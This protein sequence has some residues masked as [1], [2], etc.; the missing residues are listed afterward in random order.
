[1]GK[2]IREN[3]I[4]KEKT[5]KKINILTLVIALFL[6]A[7]I[8]YTPTA[9]AMGWDLCNAMLQQI[10]TGVIDT[11]CWNLTGEEYSKP[12][13]YVGDGDTVEAVTADELTPSGAEGKSENLVYNYFMG[14]SG[15][16][17][18][19]GKG[20]EGRNV[21]VSVFN[22]MIIFGLG[23]ACIFATGR[24]FTNMDRGMPPTEA[25]LKGVREVAFVGIFILNIDLFADLIFDFGTRV[26]SAI[27]TAATQGMDGTFDIWIMNGDQIRTAP[28]WNYTTNSANAITDHPVQ[29]LSI[30]DYHGWFGIEDFLETFL[31]LVLP[32]LAMV[33]GKGVA[34]LMCYSLLIEIGVRRALTPLAVA[35]IY[36][37]GFRS[38]G[39]RWLKKYAACFVRI[40]I[41]VMV[42]ALG[43]VV[44]GLLAHQTFGAGSTDKDADSQLMS[45]MLEYLIKVVVVNF[46]VISVIGKTGEYANEALGV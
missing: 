2:K 36:G 14:I 44:M 40:G 13:K 46:T 10:K 9:K 38:T 19:S 20:K 37:E 42:C 8:L 34:L 43:I 22:V 27:I 41:A 33:I 11:I 35:D 32:W 15:D 29:L 31:K 23:M 45:G 28:S 4:D 18:A 5:T 16:K 26:E 24:I 39:A 6:G 7:T 25:I 3:W 21:I 1:M 12:Y 30:T 17:S